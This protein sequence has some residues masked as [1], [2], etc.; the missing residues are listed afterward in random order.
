MLRF[1]V[2]GLFLPF[3]LFVLAA[4][5]RNCVWE[6]KAQLHS[7]PRSFSPLRDRAGIR[8]ASRSPRSRRRVD[9]VARAAPSATRLVNPQNNTSAPFPARIGGR[10]ESA[11]PGRSV[12]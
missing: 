10:R 7:R 11:P 12:S 6:G 8:R 4:I 2:I 3:L 9:A 1:I 5:V